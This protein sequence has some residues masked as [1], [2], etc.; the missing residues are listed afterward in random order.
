MVKSPLIWAGGK[1]RAMSHVLAE[2]LEG[3]CLIEPFVGSGSVFLNTDYKTYVLCDSNA[4]LIN[5]FSRVK[6]DTAALLSAAAELFENG[7]NETCYYRNRDAFNVFNRAYTGSREQYSTDELV[8]YAALFL[9]LNR[10]SFNGVYRVNLKNELN[11]PFGFRKNPIFPVAEIQHFAQRAWEKGA[12]FLHGDFRETIPLAVGHSN[13]VVYC[14]PPYLPA[15]ETANF[16]TYGKPF[17]DED[18]RAL[19]E[20]LSRLYNLTKIPS[21]ISGSDTPE[22]RQIYYPFTLKSFDIR[23]SVGAKTR[24]LAGEVI[25][26]LRVCDECGQ[27]GRGYCATCCPAVAGDGYESGSDSFCCRNCEICDSY[28][29]PEDF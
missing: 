23:R 5:F 10:H 26:S 29:A 27:V 3:E 16:T 7:N 1:S 25:G 6:R 18:H 15:S 24:N 14:D 22:T 17:T 4:A 19:V 8:K 12:M 11:V 20:M 28:T 21:V 13:C 2:L 9:Y